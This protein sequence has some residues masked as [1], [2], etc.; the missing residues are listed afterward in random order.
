MPSLFL[1]AT[2]RV[3][4]LELYIG[5]SVLRLNCPEDGRDLARAK[6]MA[7]NTTFGRLR[8]GPKLLRSTIAKYFSSLSSDVRFAIVKSALSVN[9]SEKGRGIV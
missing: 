9:P 8:S 1:R 3:S 2:N 6:V 4:R 7:S 5:E